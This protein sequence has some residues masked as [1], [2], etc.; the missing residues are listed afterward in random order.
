MNIREFIQDYAN[1]MKYVQESLLEFFDNDDTNENDFQLLM[2]NLEDHQQFKSNIRELRILLN[3]ISKIELQHH[4]TQNFFS[5]IEKIIKYYQDNIMNSFSNLEIFNIFKENKRILL[6]L[7]DEK[8]IIPDIN[9]YYIITKIEY[10]EGRHKFFNV[11]YYPYYFFPE[12]Q[13]FFS[14]KEIERIQS[15]LNDQNINFDTFENERRIGENHWYLSKLI[16]NDQI[17]EFITYTSQTN[18][19]LSDVEIKFSIF[20]SNHFL[21]GKSTSLIQYATF[22][23]SIRIVKYLL[24]Q[25]VKLNS[26]IYEYVIHSNNQ[27]MFFLFQEEN[28]ISNNKELLKMAI[29]CHHNDFVNYISELGNLGFDEPFE[30]HYFTEIIGSYNFT[31]LNQNCVGNEIDG[32]D[33]FYLFCKNDYYPFVEFFVRNKN[34]DIN[35]ET[36]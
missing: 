2:K 33:L 20:E 4:R 8:I 16:R 26:D 13:S 31:Y 1:K 6:F 9:L 30:T 14:P 15:L 18:L 19:S 17:E 23:G 11:E 25:G 12:F 21:F 35:W 28:V 24:H 36:V 29:C 10:Q 3:L 32:K 27:E 34:D 7:F 5:K 22:F